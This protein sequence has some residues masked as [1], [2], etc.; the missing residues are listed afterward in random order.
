MPTRDN[1]SD[2]RTVLRFNQDI[3]ADG[4]HVS[5]LIGVIDSADYDMG[6]F[7]S[8]GIV[9]FTDGVFEIQVQESDENNAGFNLIPPEKLLGSFPVLTALTAEGG[10]LGEF[11]V[12]GTKRYLKVLIAATGVTSGARLVVS[13]IEKGEYNPQDRV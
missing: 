7:F 11:G 6:I 5:T 9:E 4:N 8:A 2:Q 12:V 3:T 1:L 10:Q 13:S